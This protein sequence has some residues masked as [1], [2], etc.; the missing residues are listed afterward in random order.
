[1]EF[2]ELE[3]FKKEFKKLCKKY[4][5]FE[6][7]FLRFKNFL[8]LDPIWN[9]LPKEH[10]V[11]IAWLWE[12][13]EWEF[14][15]VRRFLCDSLRSNREIRIIYKYSKE[16]ETIEFKEII[17]FIEMYQKNEKENNDIERIKKYYSK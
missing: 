2:K 8:K 10:I 15:K 7:D 17:E 6:G 5:S 11:R 16:T 3:E 9:T 1:M 12:K 14:Y 13:I 4:K